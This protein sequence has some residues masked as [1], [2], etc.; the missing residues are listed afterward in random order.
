MKVGD[1][2]RIDKA[3]PDGCRAGVI[4]Y[5]KSFEHGKNPQPIVLID[6]VLRLYGELVCEVISE[7]Q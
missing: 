4:V 7:S 2:V 3:S 1:L 5:F 6:G